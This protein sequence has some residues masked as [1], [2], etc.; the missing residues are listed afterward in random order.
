M[1]S[2]FPHVMNVM[3]MTKI[4]KLDIWCTLHFVCALRIC[5]YSVFYHR[6][7]TID[8]ATSFHFHSRF[9]RLQSLYNRRNLLNTLYKKVSEW[10]PSFINNNAQKCLYTVEL[11]IIFVHKRTVDKNNVGKRCCR[12]SIC[13]QTESSLL[14]DVLECS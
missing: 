4:E 10:Y 1:L 3:I 13:R 9:K 14:F 11:K 12:Q 8:Q 5:R 6:T 7:S 2:Q